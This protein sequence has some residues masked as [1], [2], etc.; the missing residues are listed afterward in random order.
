M[1]KSLQLINFRG[2]RD[3]AVDFT[4][5]CLLIGRNNAGKTTLIE[6][7][8]LVATALKRAP[9]ANFQMAP[10]WLSP[11]VSGPVFRFGTEALGFDHRGVHYN[12]NWD[13]AAI[14]RARLTNHSII[15]IAVG[16]EPQDFYCQ[17]MLPGGK[18]I[19]SRSM[20]SDRRFPPIYVAP[21]IGSLLDRETLR[22][23]AYVRKNIDGYLSHRHIRNQMAEMPDE[24]AVF[25]SYVQET[26]D[27][28]LIGDIEYGVGD[29]KDEFGITVRDGPFVSELGLVGSGLQAWVQTLWFLSRTTENSTIILDEPDVY[30][31]ADLQRKLIQI[32]AKDA[33]RQT[34]VATHSLEMISAV[35]PSDIISITKRDARSK[36]LSS[37]LQAQALVDSL[38]TSSNL[39]LSKLARTG[40]ILFVEG[41]DHAYLDQ[42]AFKKGNSFYDRFSR[43]PHFATGGMSNWRRA[44][45]AAKAF[46][47]TSSGQVKSLMLLDR[48]YKNDDLIEE[49]ILEAQKSNL[50]IVFWKKKEIENYFIDC[51]VIES[52][53]KTRLGSEQHLDGFSE[54]FN[55]IMADLEL[56]LPELIADTLQATDRKLA[57]PTAMKKAREY[58]SEKKDLG[59]PLADLISGKR[60][61][62]KLSDACKERFGVSFSPMSICRQMTLS[63]MN[64]EVST[65]LDRFS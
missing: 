30:L 65:F 39:Q 12:Y 35:S 27:H 9:T 44:A 47:E 22:D 42:L 38:G 56:E 21:P 2:F 64:S 58:I 32:L 19:N 26:W 23:R 11:Q 63:Q 49:V 14:V 7:L 43:I 46:A 61:V 52:F 17:L 40:H 29:K 8:R 31:H 48:D 53:V 28:L 36:A 62:S 60:M 5:F 13:E 4:A 34:I 18:K 33:F 15:V 3:H 16:P 55:R 20:I 10:E 51:D 24:F 54:T 25:R 37:N 50:E 41:K 59:V 45:M 6:A 57:L 1:L